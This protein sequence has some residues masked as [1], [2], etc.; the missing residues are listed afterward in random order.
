MSRKQPNPPPPEN[1]RPKPPPGPPPLQSLNPCDS[2]WKTQDSEHIYCNATQC[3][4]RN[5]F[6]PYC[7]IAYL[8]MEY[9]NE[10]GAVVCKTY[11]KMKGFKKMWMI[12]GAS[13]YLYKI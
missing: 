4:H 12:K 13:Y 1:V 7:D 11:Q 3:I 5:I 10:I 9:D 8:T 6:H 2:R